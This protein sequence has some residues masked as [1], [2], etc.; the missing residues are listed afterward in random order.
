MKNFNFYLEEFNQLK[1]L[2]EEKKETNER[3]S[4]L[5]TLE[6]LITE[7]KQIVEGGKKGLDILKKLNQKP[8]KNV[9]ENHKKFIQLLQ[10]MEFIYAKA[11]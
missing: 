3:S 6:K 2:L 4:V 5:F 7:V 10:D 11:K 8:E 9:E 1:N